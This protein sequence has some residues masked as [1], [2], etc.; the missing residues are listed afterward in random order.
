MGKDFDRLAAAAVESSKAVG[1]TIQRAGGSIR[2]AR[3]GVAQKFSFLVHAANISQAPGPQNISGA[4]LCHRNRKEPPMLRRIGIWALCGAAVAL[5]WAFVFYMAGPS[6]GVYPSQGAVL[7]Y[8]SHTPLLPITAPVAL[9]G[10]HYAITWFWSVVMNASIYA[11]A[12]LIVE[13]TRLAFHSSFARL[14]H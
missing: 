13:T 3:N 14:R 11:C 7:H 5:V 6:H 10:Q 12:G 1:S 9:L 8:L 2:K 4:R